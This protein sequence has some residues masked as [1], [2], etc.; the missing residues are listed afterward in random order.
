MRGNAKLFASAK[1]KFP[2]TNTM[3]DSQK[4]IID[5]ERNGFVEGYT[6]AES[7]YQDIAKD[8]IELIKIEAE[9]SEVLEQ[10]VLFPTQQNKSK[11][12]SIK[13]KLSTIESKLLE[14]MKIYGLVSGV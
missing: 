12:N 5:S 9:F 6:E 10:T 3:T 8:F 14:L 4:L 1:Q 7:H 11:L 13:C 2:Y